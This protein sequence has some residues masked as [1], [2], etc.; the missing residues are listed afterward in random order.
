MHPQNK[1]TGKC[2]LQPHV[3]LILVVLL[4]CRSHEANKREFVATMDAVDR[5]LGAA[6]SP[7][8]LGAE[9]SMVDIVFA[10][11][12]ERIAASILYYKGLIVRG[13]GCADTFYPILLCLEDFM[14]SCARRIACRA[15]ACSPRVSE[16]VAESS[17]SGVVCTP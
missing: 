9:L 10:P 6:G 11:F 5:E 8:F 13:E 7:F 16:W 4:H 2:S 14:L 3:F 12:L 1:Y 15:A 17:G